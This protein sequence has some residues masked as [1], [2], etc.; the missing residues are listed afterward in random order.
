MKTLLTAVAI[1]CSRLGWRVRRGP[2]RAGATA[3]HPLHHD[4]RPRGARHQR[5]RQRRSTR[6]RTSTASR[7]EGALFTNV[8]RHQLDLHAE[9]RGDPHR[10]V[11]P[12]QRRARVQPLRRL[13]ADRREAAAG[14][15]LP[16]RHGRQVAPRQ[17]SDRLRP[18]GDPAR[19]G[20]LHRPGASTPRPARRRT[21]GYATDVITDLAIDFL[22]EA[23]DGQAVLPDAAP[24]GAAP[25]VDAG[26][27]ARRAVRGR[28]R[29]PSRRRCAT[30]TPRAPTRCSENQQRC[31]T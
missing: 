9:P 22:E 26:R 4:R 1:R 29:S 8:L 20:R 5:L 24:Q 3:E 15:R 10:Q 14:G 23:A 6:R 2:A 19:P 31:A 7:K 18:L 25:A 28:R 16:H 17:R 21:P 30:T 12:P 27:E 13:A 11:Q